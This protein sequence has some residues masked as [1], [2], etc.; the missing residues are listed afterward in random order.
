MSAEPAFRYAFAQSPCGGLAFELAGV[1]ALLRPSGALWLEVERTLIVADLHLEKGSAYAARGQLLPPYDTRET[2]A[3]LTAEAGRLRPRTIVLLGDTLH[4]KKAEDRLGLEDA[5]ALGALAAV[6]EL[7]WIVGNH[8]A[9]GPRGLPGES[10]ATCS[11]AGLT[12][13]HEPAAA[14]RWGEV[15]GHLH[16][17][18]RVKSRGEATRRRCFVSD[19][20]RLVMPAFG[21][22]AGGLN[23]RDVAFAGLFRR[24]PLAVALG[25]RRAHAVGWGQ[26]G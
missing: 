1:E 18:A 23:V 14:P 3:R 21:A 19:G 24:R 12:L 4:D 11:V 10:R 8:D 6:A 26:L 22:F 13:T 20:E 9:D 15:A 5:C 7:V 17:C 25:A 2:L 16:P